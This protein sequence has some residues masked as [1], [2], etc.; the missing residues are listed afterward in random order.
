MERY[1]IQHLF[2]HCKVYIRVKV[3]RNQFKI[4]YIQFKFLEYKF[5]VGNSNVVYQRHMSIFSKQVPHNPGVTCS[6]GFQCVRYFYGVT[7]RQ[8]ARHN[9]KEEVSPARGQT[10][11][12]RARSPPAYLAPTPCQKRGHKTRLRVN[13][14]RSLRRLLGETRQQAATEKRLVSSLTPPA[15]FPILHSPSSWLRARNMR[16]CP[17]ILHVSVTFLQRGFS[18][19]ELINYNI[20]NIINQNINYI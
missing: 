10:V 14:T 13:K 4:Q 7:T 15:P 20:N 6:K 8:R 17:R 3:T 18:P 12:G 9:E 16:L 19:L 11:T 2:I 1:L 5:F